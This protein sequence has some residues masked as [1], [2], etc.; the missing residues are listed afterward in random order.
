MITTFSAFIVG[1]TQGQKN[2]GSKQGSRC[3]AMKLIFASTKTIQLARR[4]F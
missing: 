4:P 1:P 2:F 3:H